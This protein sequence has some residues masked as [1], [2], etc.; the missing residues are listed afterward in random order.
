MSEM[1]IG[2]S[3]T[4][5]RM[6]RASAPEQASRG[7]SPWAAVMR[8]RTWRTCGSSST[9]R[10]R[11]VALSV[12]VEVTCETKYGYGLLAIGYGLLLAWNSPRPIAHSRSV[13]S[14]PLWL[15]FTHPLATDTDD[16]HS[17]AGP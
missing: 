2:T 17:P 15:I 4:R 16:S 7:D 8:M 10:Q 5:L 9:M 11:A 14:L 1:Q 3:P 12:G 13:P 6:A